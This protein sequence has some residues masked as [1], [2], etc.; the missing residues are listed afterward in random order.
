[1]LHVLIVCAGSQAKSGGQMRRHFN[2]YA[3]ILV[4]MLFMALQGCK[5]QNNKEDLG[6]SQEELTLQPVKLKPMPLGSIK[7]LGWLKNQLQIQAD[8]LSGHL[9][10]FWPDISDSAWFGGESDAWERA[11]YWLDGVVPLAYLLEDENLTKKVTDYMDH[12]ISNQD[13][14]GWISPAEDR[15]GYDLWAIFLVL[16]P[17]IQY[18]DATGDER[19]PKVVEETLRWVE[20]HIDRRPLFNWG[21]FR[22]FESL[23][24]IYWL[25][26]RTQEDWLLDLAVK[27]Q[28]QGFDWISFFRRFP[29]KGITPKGKWTYMGHVVNNGMAVKAPAL[30]WR[31]TGDE[32]DRNMVYKM[33]EKQDLYHGQ[34]TGIFSGDECFAG[35]NPS[36]GTELCAVVEYQFSLEVLMSILGDPA[37]GDRLEKVTFNAL[38]ATFSPDMWSHQY[39]QQVNQAECSIRENRL[40]TTNGPESNIFGLEPNYGCCTSNLSQGW[41]KFAAHLWMQ[42]EDEGL[43][44]VAYAPNKVST[45]IKNVPVSIEVVTD[46]PFRQDIKLKVHVESP[47]QFPLHLRIP[48]WSDE[49]S[50]SVGES[51]HSPVAGSFYVLDRSWTGT[52]E[53]SIVLPMKPRATRRYNNALALERGPLL[54]ALKIGEEWKRVNEDKPHRELPHADWEVYP[55]TPWNYALDLNLETLNQLNFEEHPIG[56]TPFSPEGAPVSVK[57]KGTRIDLWKM[58]NGSPGELP[59]SPVAAAGDLVEL[60]LI[61]YGC[62]NLRIAEFPTL[63]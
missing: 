29:L 30:W 44:A 54:Y 21:K 40:W 61:P 38:P 60:I 51:Q 35:K 8:G 56:E 28:A 32:R 47:V 43:A 19:V 15:S 39:D 2:V 63:K 18:H 13:E 4:V 17:L 7:P 1:M 33:M 16:K 22:W 31:L 53:V 14:S 34:A 62:T 59:K 27:L 46:Y 49:A 42:T 41:P 12:I 10:E 52:T 37:F 20:G 6:M 9:D 5:E 24:S 3:G 58:E 36:Q 48:A 50:I 57:V 26:E 23:I 55:T 25:Y 45:R 11:P